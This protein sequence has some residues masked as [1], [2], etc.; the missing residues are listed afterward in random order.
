LSLDALIND[1]T[2][3]PATK[4]SPGV[5]DRRRS[6]ALRRTVSRLRQNGGAS[7]SIFASHPYFPL[8]G[9]NAGKKKKRREK[10]AKMI[11][12]TA[13]TALIFAA[14]FP[15]VYTFVSFA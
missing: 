5:P 9:E 15:V 1:F 10:M 2:K 8:I 11:S 14:L 12:I 13:A 6:T 7:H 4:R 3:P